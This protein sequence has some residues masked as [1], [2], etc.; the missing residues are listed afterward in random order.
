MID[1]SEHKNH[2]LYFSVGKYPYWFK[3]DKDKTY[4]PYTKPITHSSL[5][6]LA[7]LSFSPNYVTRFLQDS[8][9]IITKL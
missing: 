8:T 3:S 4:S 1:N 6:R 9:I 5:Y 7:R 2:Q